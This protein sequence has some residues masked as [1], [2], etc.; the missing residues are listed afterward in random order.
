MFGTQTEADGPVAFLGR[1]SY[2]GVLNESDLK[3]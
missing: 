1:C 2:A 3:V